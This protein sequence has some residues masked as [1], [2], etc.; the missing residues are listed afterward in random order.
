MNTIDWSY[1]LTVVLQPA[2]TAAVMLMAQIPLL[3]THR[4]E[5]KQ[6]E[7]ELQDFRKFILQV[8]VSE[9]DKIIL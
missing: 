8:D 3:I 4:A 6:H 5:R 1:V 2:V 9:V 7:R